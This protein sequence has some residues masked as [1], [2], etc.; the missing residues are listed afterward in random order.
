MSRSPHKMRSGKGPA[1]DSALDHILSLQDKGHTIGNNCPVCLDQGVPSCSITAVSKRF[2]I[3]RMTLSDR[4]NK[5]TSNRGPGRPST[6]SDSTMEQ[7]EEASSEQTPHKLIQKGI[8]KHKR[9]ATRI[10]QKIALRKSKQQGL[11]KETE[12]EQI[13]EKP[14]NAA[15][16]S[17]EEIR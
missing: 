13:P 5:K 11:H 2:D 4:Y 10:C 8:C 1:V 9:T 6:V 17:S 16:D 14:E 15:D 7:L 3:A 12:T